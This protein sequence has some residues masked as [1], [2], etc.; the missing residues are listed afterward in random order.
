M[1]K[2]QSTAYS[3]G[4]SSGVTDP[5]SGSDTAAG[6]RWRKH[7]RSD[8]YFRPA[9]EANTFLNRS[10]NR[11]ECP[12]WNDQAPAVLFYKY[13]FYMKKRGIIHYE[14]IHG[15]KLSTLY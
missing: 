13:N 12:V 2:L 5:A 8:D 14:T 3:G 15:Q 4:Q 11:T 9:R 6:S 1:V 7:T 10:C